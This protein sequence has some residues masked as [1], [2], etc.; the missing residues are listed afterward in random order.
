MSAVRVV[1]DAA[2]LARAA[3][4]EVLQAGAAARAQRRDFG[5]ALAGGGTPRATYE[6]LARHGRTPFRHWRVFFGDERCVPPEHPDSNYGTARRA[7]LEPAGIPEPRIHRMHG[8]AAPAA[9]A[10]Q[11]E[12]EI[13]VAFRGAPPRFD[14]I[15]LGLGADGHTA[16][17][18]PGTS[19]LE[20]RQR[21]VRE[22]WVEPLA[23]WRITMTLP[24]LNLARRVV[25][26]VAG[27]DKAPALRAVL[28][29]NPAAPRLPAAR[30]AP[31]AGQ[32]LWLVDRAAAQLLPP[33]P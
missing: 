26:L 32:V 7:L 10:A 30:V 28:Q 31:P 5:I 27:A 25:F 17:L 16:S 22:N 2:E 12:R 14:L 9:A 20:E 1:A 23:A 15:L 3:A 8:E 21:W 33:A 24:L 4:A 11:Y 19:A 18:F 6:E 13:A 29:P